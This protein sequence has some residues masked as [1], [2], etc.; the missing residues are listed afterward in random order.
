[1]IL[2]WYNK[3]ASVMVTPKKWGTRDGLFMECTRKW[4]T[5]DGLCLVIHAGSTDALWRVS[6]LNAKLPHHPAGPSTWRRG[7][8]VMH[9]G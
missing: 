7:I 8:L 5:M 2:M 1:M 4:G 6:S 9:L 3:C